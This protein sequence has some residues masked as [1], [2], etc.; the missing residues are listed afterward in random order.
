MA[1]ARTTD[2]ASSHLAAA[3]VEA[4]GA[5]ARQARA[6]LAAVARWPGRTAREISDSTGLDRYAVSRRLPELEEAGEVR[7]GAMRRCQVGG[8][9]SLT[10]W[11]ADSGQGELF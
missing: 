5:G 2:P 4:S 11:V 3:D 7:R 1:R 9:Q 10:W 6:V 8:R